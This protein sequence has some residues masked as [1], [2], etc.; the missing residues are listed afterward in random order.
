MD[1]NKIKVSAIETLSHSRYGMTTNIF[2]IQV[3][4][5]SSSHEKDIVAVIVKANGETIRQKLTYLRTY[6][7]NKLDSC[8]DETWD[9]YISI[10]NKEDVTPLKFYVEHCDLKGTVVCTDHSY[11]DPYILENFGSGF[12]IY[13]D[14]LGIVDKTTP[15]TSD[16][17]IIYFTVFARMLSDD[18]NVTIVYSYD[19]WKTVQRNWMDKSTFLN[20][21]AGYSSETNPQHIQRLTFLSQKPDNYSG[22]KFYYELNFDGQTIYCN[23]GSHFEFQ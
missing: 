22:V 12:L 3:I 1:K 5:C 6:G 9:S 7:N 11:N 4:S 13:I 18:Q 2:Y 23:N 16:S 20:G 19:D 17:P 14:Q 15:P 10:T 21:Y 8:R